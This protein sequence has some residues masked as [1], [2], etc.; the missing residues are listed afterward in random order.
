MSERSVCLFQ[1]LGFQ[2][3]AEIRWLGLAL[4]VLWSP[5]PAIPFVI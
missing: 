2:L 4:L 3:G 5:R 1:L